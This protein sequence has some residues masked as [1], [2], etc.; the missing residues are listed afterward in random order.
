MRRNDNSLHEAYDPDRPAILLTSNEHDHTYQNNSQEIG[1]S[2]A[3][4]WNPSDINRQNIKK[5]G[6]RGRSRGGLYRNEG[7][8]HS[9]ASPSLMIENIPDDKCNLDSINQFFKR[10]GTVVN[11]KVQPNQK[12]AIIQFSRTAEATA[13][14]RS[15]DPIFENRFVK[16]FYLPTQDN[17]TPQASVEAIR[18]TVAP[19]TKVDPAPVPDAVVEEQRRKFSELLKAKEKVKLATDIQKK[20]KELVEKQI[21]QQ[22]A[23]LAKLENPSLDQKDREVLMITLKKLNES[24]TPVISKPV[25]QIN[26]GINSDSSKLFAQ[27]QKLDSEL[28]AYHIEATKKVQDSENLKS[29][30]ESLR[31]E[32]V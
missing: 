14:I 24:I 16:I 5:S 11:I 32:V 8:R 15:P 17:N 20:K 22:K 4:H 30:L 29:S 2:R 3:D 6:I 9:Q 31:A 28:E 27:K 13:A 23:I 21:Q 1:Q 25:S 7:N 19:I 12:N 10:F 18:P 26:L